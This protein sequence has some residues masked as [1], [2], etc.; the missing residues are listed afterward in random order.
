MIAALGAV[1]LVAA[2]L[3]WP[4]SSAPMR[5]DVPGLPESYALACD[6][7]SQRFEIPPAEYRRALLKRADTSSNRIRCPRCGAPGAA[8]RSDHG[9]PGLPAA[10]PEAARNARWP[11]KPP[12]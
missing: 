8:F 2:M 7:C 6:S 1:G 5:P 3:V 12:G 9:V 11:G 10:D 4:G